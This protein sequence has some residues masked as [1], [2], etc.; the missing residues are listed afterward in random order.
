M[1]SVD[2]VPIEQ[3]M[4]AVAEFDQ[5]ARR[6][7][8]RRLCW[9][10][11]TERRDAHFRLTNEFGSRVVSPRVLVIFDGLWFAARHVLPVGL[12]LGLRISEE[13]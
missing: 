12:G 8:I 6:L 11:R 10:A 4:I 7:L 1:F 9:H 3:K 2:P 5:E 13:R